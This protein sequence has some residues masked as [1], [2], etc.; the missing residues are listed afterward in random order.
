[1]RFSE[2]QIPL[3][4]KGFIELVLAILKL[5]LALKGSIDKGFNRVRGNL[6]VLCENPHIGQEGYVSKKFENI[7]C[8][9]SGTL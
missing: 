6:A 8:F 7:P 5:I 2:N 1:M 4:I 9:F 3:N